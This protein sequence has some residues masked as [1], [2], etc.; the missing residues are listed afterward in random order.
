MKQI[1]YLFLLI[2]LTG[3]PGNYDFEYDIIITSQATN[4]GD[5]NT[6]YDDFNSDLPYD[7]ANADIFFSSNR[8]SQGD[9]FDIIAKGLSFSYH[10][11]DNILNLTIGNDYVLEEKASLLFE[12]VNTG[13]DELGPFSFYYERDLLSLYATDLND[14]FKINLV[15][16]LNWNTSQEPVIS[17]PKEIQ[18]INDAGNNLYPSYN[19]GESEMFFCS[20]RND[21]VF[22]IYTAIYNHKISAQ[23]LLSGNIK[24]I[25]KEEVLS[26]TYD[27]KCPYVKEDM[28][29]FTSNRAGSYD[30]YYSYFKNGLWS[31]PQTFGANVNTE[32]DEYR[33]VIFEMLGFNLMIFSS[34]RPGGQ[35]GYD[36]YIVNIE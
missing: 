25:Q 18:G 31:S 35:G 3:C 26:S 30:L 2:L 11:K 12:K 13:N 19:Q 22:N 6:Q 17:E 36:L 7:Y 10:D 28:L 14:T 21:S 20:D 16:Y 24:S 15:E 32:Y 29:V 23:T 8:N 34:N 27:D 9:N 4:L 1:F 33:P 5:L